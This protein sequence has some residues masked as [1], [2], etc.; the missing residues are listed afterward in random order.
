[1]SAY[2]VVANS[3][4]V[5]ESWLRKL[6]GRQPVVVAA[7]EYLNLA[8]LYVRLCERIE[9]EAEHERRRAAALREAAHAALESHR[10]VVASTPRPDRS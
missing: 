4:G 9:A 6:I 5:S 2:S 10:G 1:M 8:A 3:L 7:H